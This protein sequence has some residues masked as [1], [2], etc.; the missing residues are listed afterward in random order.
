MDGQP[1][2]EL[3]T[4]ILG[5]LQRFERRALP[6]AGRRRAAV[7]LVIGKAAV[8]GEPCFVLTRRASSL[9]AH[10]GQWALPGG[11]CDAGET[12][13]AAAVRETHEEIGVALTA[14]AALG[15]L[16]DYATRSGY[17]ITPVVLW[18]GMH[19][20]FAPNPGEVA[21]VY[22]VP[23][24]E[25][26]HPRVPELRQIPESDRPVISVPLPSV[27]SAIHAP[28]AAILYQLWEVA[29]AGR[30]TRV[31]HYEQPVFAWR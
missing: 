13:V 29:L 1:S 30:A 6:S 15:L 5:N 31:A 25:L 18:H 8:S 22:E 21:G 10:A 20:S 7:A 11:R 17:V 28:T 3:R 24:A 2:P 19:F 12:A 14:G 9:P 16:D 27:N 4:Q 23:L 26:G